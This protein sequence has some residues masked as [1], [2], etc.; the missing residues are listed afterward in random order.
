MSDCTC[1]P[2]IRAAWQKKQDHIKRIT[3]LAMA[4]GSCRECFSDGDDFTAADDRICFQISELENAMCEVA[5]RL[6]LADDIHRDAMAAASK[7]IKPA[8]S[9][10]E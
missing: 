3:A 9:D 6:A 10:A 1:N 7:A 8:D 2:V 5:H 4:I